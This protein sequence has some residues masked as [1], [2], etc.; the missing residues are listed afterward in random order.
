MT[1]YSSLRLYR[2]L[3]STFL[4]NLMTTHLYSS[5]ASAGAILAERHDCTDGGS[6]AAA[7]TFAQLW[8]A[9]CG[10]LLYAAGGVAVSWLYLMCLTVLLIASVW[11]LRRVIV[12]SSFFPKGCLRAVLINFSTKLRKGLYIRCGR[13]FLSTFL[14]GGAPNLRILVILTVIF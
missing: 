3:V 8:M 9:D 13:F 6:G 2:A 7:A 1:L 10:L 5:T 4:L 11:R 12:S 14:C